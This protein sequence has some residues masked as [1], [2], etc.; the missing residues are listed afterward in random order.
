MVER[1]LSD[2]VRIAELLAS[3]LAGHG[4]RLADVE[5]VDADP[6]AEPSADG[7]FAYAVERGDR[8]IATV[9]VHPDRA[10]I[11]FRDDPAA[12]AAAARERGLRTRRVAADPPRTLVFVEDGAA[13]KRALRT[14]EAVA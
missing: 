6:D 12:A 7:T 5:P 1:R 2:G 4:G 10:R 13:V 3:E 9:H 11:V 14:V 8:R